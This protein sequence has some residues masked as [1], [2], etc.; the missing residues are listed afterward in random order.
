MQD[1]T[2]IQ[3]KNMILKQEVIERI[4]GRTDI[5]PLLVETLDLHISSI[6]RILNENAPNGQLTTVAAVE[7]ISR[8]L[9]VEASEVLTETEKQLEPCIEA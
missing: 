3:V 2:K 9:G 1:I 4:K 6:N 7:V 8:L 5:K